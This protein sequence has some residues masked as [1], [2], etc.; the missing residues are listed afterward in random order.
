MTGGNNYLAP[1]APSRSRATVL[2]PGFP[3]AVFRRFPCPVFGLLFLTMVP[4]Q[5]YG[6]ESLS[7]TDGELM[8]RIRSE[9][10]TVVALASSSDHCLPSRG[11]GNR[12]LWSRAKNSGIEVHSIKASM[13][14][15]RLEQFVTALV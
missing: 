15:L 13:N 10:G 11:S 3:I 8:G 14:E 2:G 5:Q 9:A 6:L 7:P 4:R 1:L 12:A